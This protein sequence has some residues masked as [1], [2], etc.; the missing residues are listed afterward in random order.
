MAKQTLKHL[1]EQLPGQDVITAADAVVINRQTFEIPAGD[2]SVIELIDQ[3]GP[4]YARACMDMA[5]RA[6]RGDVDPLQ[7]GDL[8]HKM[9]LM[10]AHK[11]IPYRKFK[12]QAP[13]KTPAETKKAARA[14]T[15]IINKFSQDGEIITKDSKINGQQIMD[16]G[17]DGTVNWTGEDEQNEKKV[18]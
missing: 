8:P 4:G 17:E 5:R 3:A 2:L 9:A 11:M 1:L 14:L 16:V 13:D 10:L 6:M 12:D 7:E 18:A 15:Q